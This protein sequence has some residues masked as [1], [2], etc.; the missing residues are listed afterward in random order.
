LWILLKNEI[1][2]FMKIAI[3]NLKGGVGKTTIAV[4][5]A[6]SFT[7]RGKKV[8]IIDTDQKQ[9]SA[10][11]WAGIRSENRPLIQVVAM[12]QNQ[13]N[14]KI[15]ADFE[16]KFDVVLLDG[17][18][19]LSELATRTILV[20]DILII[21]ISPSIFDFRAFESFLKLV[22]EMN[23]NRVAA[24]LKEVQPYIV[25]NRINQSANIAKEIGEALAGY[26]TPLTAT[27]LVNRTAYADTA[28][29]GLGVVE[30]KDK[31]AKDEFN[32]FT[33]EIETIIAGIVK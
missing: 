24:G 10:L 30:G 19:Q 25:L 14:N 23:E 15:L 16:E 3:T 20:S 8:C 29:D 33:D 12:G 28:S 18:P 27:R 5:L 7:A 31:K 32:R 21:P 2:R 17:T 26:N 1:L 9:H 11:E 22:N 6:A 13:I 4:N